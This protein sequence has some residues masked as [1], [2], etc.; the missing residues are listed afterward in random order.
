LPLTLDLLKNVTLTADLGSG[1]CTVTAKV[2][3]AQSYFRSDCR[4]LPK[5]AVAIRTLGWRLRIESCLTNRFGPFSRVGTLFGVVG[6]SPLP[7]SLAQG[8]S[9]YA[10]QSFTIPMPDQLLW[11]GEN[12]AIS[13]IEPGKRTHMVG[14]KGD[15]NLF[16]PAI[17]FRPKPLNV[18]LTQPGISNP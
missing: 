4:R 17:R 13:R 11:F 5:R 15:R 6:Q 1:G 16:C 7:V 8:V 18:S 12:E 2:R 3:S 9:V 10:V 14:R